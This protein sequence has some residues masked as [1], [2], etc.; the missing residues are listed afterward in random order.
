MTALENRRRREQ[1]RKSVSL[2]RK[3]PFSKWR[4]QSLGNQQQ[5]IIMND[6]PEA[7]Q[8]DAVTA[9]LIK[10][11]VLLLLQDHRT[12]CTVLS[13]ANALFGSDRVKSQYAKANV[14][15]QMKS[16]RERLAR[17]F[18][19]SSSGQRNDMDALK[20][21]YEYVDALR[22]LET[23]PGATTKSLTTWEE[24]R[25]ELSPIFNFPEEET[26]LESAS[27]GKY[28]VMDEFTKRLNTITLR[29]KTVG[30][31]PSQRI[32]QEVA[33]AALSPKIIGEIV[34]KLDKADQSIS[35]RLAEEYALEK[36]RRKSKAAEHIEKV[37][38]EKEA[39]ERAAALMRPL[40]K[41][42]KQIVRKAISGNGPPGEVIAQV[43]TDSI[44]RSSMAT[45][46][47]GGW[48][49]DEVIHYFYVMLSVRDEEMCKQDPNRKRSHFFKSFFITKLLNEGHSDRSKDGQY[50][51]KNVKRWSKK[52]PGKYSTAIYCRVSKGIVGDTALTHIVSSCLLCR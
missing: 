23:M 28:S 21:R 15:S 38:R 40:T 26:S 51:Y 42:E 19:R 49:S 17:L 45:L 25:K 34:E 24:A 27:T 12:P 14:P 3:S 2:L 18:P 48:L 29:D 43:G 41:K 1:Q 16:P 11:E 8:L 7:L 22:K 6:S 36:E 30:L 50:E 44:Q 20:R 46:R 4:R 52:V 31:R 47:P 10:M 9:A 32:W 37:R 5:R 13:V 33:N 35:Q 39:E